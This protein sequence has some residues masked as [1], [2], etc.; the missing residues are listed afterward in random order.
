MV[1]EIL[2]KNHLGFNLLLENFKLSIQNLLVVLD[3]S[4]YFILGE[5]WSSVFFEELIYFF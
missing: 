5:F 2:Q 3:Y 4:D 1:G